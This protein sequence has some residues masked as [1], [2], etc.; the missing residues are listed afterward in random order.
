MKNIHIKK[1][2]GILFFILF[3]F[4][5]IIAVYGEDAS[6]NIPINGTEVKFSDKVIV[7][8]NGNVETPATISEL[9]SFKV[10]GGTLTTNYKGDTRNYGNLDSQ[11][12]N[13]FIFDRSGN[14]KE[15]YFTPAQSGKYRLGNKEF[16]VPAGADVI[17]KD[18]VA[19][20]TKYGGDKIEKPTK[21][22]SI[23]DPSEDIILA[24]QS[25]KGGFT[26][27]NGDKFT[28]I[29]KY[30]DGFFFDSDAK[31]G[32]LEIKNPEQVPTYLFYDGEP[33]DVD[34]AYI[35][36]DKEKGK[37]T[38]GCN[39]DV[40]G[41]IV[42][43]DEGNPF[44]VRIEKGDN[45]AMRP[46]GNSQGS[47]IS[48]QNREKDGKVPYVETMNQ[49]MMN[50]DGKSVYFNTNDGKLHLKTNGVLMNE[51]GESF[52][53]SGSTPLEVHGFKTIDGKKMDISKYANVLG[54]GNMNNFGYGPDPKFI[55]T[56]VL[57]Y[58]KQ[59]K[60]PGL[61]TGFSNSLAYN[62]DHTLRGLQKFVGVPITDS[63]GV[64][65][66][67]KNIQ[68][69][70]DIFAG[71]PTKDFKKWGVNK[72]K[73]VGSGWWAGLADPSDKTFYINVNGGGFNPGVIRHEL[74]H[75]HDFTF[76]YSSSFN[77]EWRAIGG[78]AGPHTYSYGYTGAEDTSTFAEFTYRTDPWKNWLSDSYKY[79]AK[80]RARIAV[81]TK[82]GFMSR[83]EASRLYSLG[84]LPSDSSDAALDKY[85][86][87]R[88][89]AF[90]T[91]GL[92][93]IF[94]GELS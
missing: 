91:I 86:A 68:M 14:L 47:Y 89:N 70:M 23:T 48:I 92:I 88:K 3:S 77:K 79:S 52:A 57:N 42:K 66:D 82:Y 35:S 94:R 53:N 5:F 22:D 85:I 25:D 28:G 2:I 81:F 45:F 59:K 32:S 49:W 65:K 26:L 87:A 13:E 54:I 60:A 27:E 37:L 75:M 78:D 69:L 76:G 20:I 64:T 50:Q 90:K 71:I 34:A 31:I 7:S 55:K 83:S 56:H 46:L 58:Y 19:T 1:E 4:T 61:F 93:I 12:R 44:G 41:P 63:V 36:M 80:F 6:G 72:F 11:K 30:R 43:L 18:G 84:G 67:P 73:I 74:T 38:V 33:K 62:Y 16:S 17:Y 51:F 40:K 39:V 21:I 9:N 8:W 15:A 10:K 29:L 24:Y